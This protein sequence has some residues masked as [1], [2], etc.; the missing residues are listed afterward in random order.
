MFKF[1]KVGQ[2]VYK[3]LAIILL[4]FL[5][6]YLFKLF[7]TFMSIVV[8]LLVLGS[9]GF[10]IYAY[11]SEKQR[12]FLR[13]E[14]FKKNNLFFRYGDE[15][16]HK[17]MHIPVKEYWG[18][19]ESGKFGYEIIDRIQSTFI[20]SYGSNPLNGNQVVAI[21][22]ATDRER[23][24]DA[25]GFLKISFSGAR[26]AIFSRFITFQVL[27]KNVVIHLMMYLLGMPKLLDIIYFVMVSPFSIW[28]WLFSWLREEYSIYATLAKEINNSF[29]IIDM[30]AYFASTKEVIADC[31]IEALKVHDLYT[32]NLATI[33]NNTFNNSNVNFGNQSFDNSVNVQ[34]GNSG[35]VGYAINQ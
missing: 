35:T 30:L 29:E 6:L 23:A 3:V 25:R 16:T 8:L 12:L 19:E 27:G 10:T 15:V 17:T 4:P 22:G 2:K 34:G 26:G 32:P 5:Y 24:S 28:T 33:V 14:F 13:N 20:D 9:I 21:I 11:I 18:P 31:I 1:I 7:G